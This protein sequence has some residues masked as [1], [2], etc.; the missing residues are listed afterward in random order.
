LDE[1]VPH[2]IAVVGSNGKTSTAHFIQRTLEGPCRTGL[3]TSP[4]LVSW[5]ERLLLG[6]RPVA[7]KDLI[8]EL[9]RHLALGNG[10][11]TGDLRFFDVLTIASE[12]LMARD[13][14]ELGIFEAGIGGR[15]DAVSVLAP[16]LT[17]LTSISLEHT[18]LLGDSSGDILREKLGIAPAGGQVVLPRFEDESL[19]EVAEGFAARNRLVIHQIPL[20]PEAPF[21]ERNRRLAEAACRIASDLFPDV[22]ERG[23]PIDTKSTTVPGRLERGAVDGVPYVCDV[24]H[25]PD[26]WHQ[27]LRE[28]R[29]AAVPPLF[30]VA[31]I[32]RE[33]D[34]A[35]LARVIRDEIDFE[36][37]ITTR[38]LIRDSHPAENLATAIGSPGTVVTA[39]DHVDSA[40]EGAFAL[41]AREGGT[42]VIFGSV[43]LVADFMSWLGGARSRA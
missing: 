12:S 22:I 7:D 1:R 32:T 3:F 5:T 35:A 11:T 8:R 40:F 16:E 31:G 17:V 41:A 29:A 6:G 26:A 23:A 33:R 13:G 43:Y 19:N 15:L 30:G 36:Q 24:G 42:V 10:E 39:S 9:T 34:P 20:P 37:L 25:N 4:H 27:A 18:D 21:L 2:H 38:S 14:I 28:V